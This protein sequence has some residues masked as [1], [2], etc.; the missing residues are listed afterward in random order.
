MAVRWFN[1]GALEF[2][3]SVQQIHDREAADAR[4]VF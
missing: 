3:R 4:Q 2:R 1:A